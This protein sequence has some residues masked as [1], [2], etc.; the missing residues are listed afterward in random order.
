MIGVWVEKCPM[1]T[2]KTAVRLPVQEAISGHG[3]DRLLEFRLE[4]AI[5]V[6]VCI[7]GIGRVSAAVS[8]SIKEII[9]K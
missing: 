4:N 9:L 1:E 7:R 3:N 2:I 6:I 8:S 5:G